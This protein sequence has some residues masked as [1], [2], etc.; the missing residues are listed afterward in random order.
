MTIK[1]NQPT[2]ILGASHTI[3]SYILPGHDLSEN[4]PIKIPVKIG[5]CLEIINGVKEKRFQMGLIETPL[6]DDDLQ[7]IKWLENELIVCSKAPLPEEITKEHLKQYRL[8]AREEGSSTRIYV[9]SF[10]NKFGLSY[11]NF[12]ALHQIDNATAAI[13][14]IKWS[15]PKATLP[16]ITIV[17]KRA[18]EEELNKGELFAAKLCKEGMHHHYHF[19]YRKDNENI[20]IIEQIIN[21]VQQIKG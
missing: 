7:Y 3:G 14:S 5:N 2:F 15:N 21:R 8:L 9:E 18:I 20:Q 16:S 4:L 12:G 13:Q 11:E 10:L 19:I 1:I 17:S 6:F